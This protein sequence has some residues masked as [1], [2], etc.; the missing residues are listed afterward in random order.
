MSATT[1]SAN[2]A[3]TQRGECPFQLRPAKEDIAGFVHA[4]SR[5]L[6]DK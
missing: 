5:S 1:T 4:A 3:L 6:A 2:Q